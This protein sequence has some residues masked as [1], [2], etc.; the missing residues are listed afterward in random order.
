MYGGQ[1]IQRPVG[2]FAALLGGLFIFNGHSDTITGEPEL[3][4]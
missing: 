4:L 2:V 3:P 1:V